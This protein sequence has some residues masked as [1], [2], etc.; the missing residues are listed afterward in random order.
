MKIF[1]IIIGA[2]ILAAAAVLCACLRGVA[3]I[4]KEEDRRN[5]VLMEDDRFSCGL[6]EED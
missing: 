6:I 3:A 2:V 5:T 1:A 4:S